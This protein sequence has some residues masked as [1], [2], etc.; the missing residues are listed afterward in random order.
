M[1][2]VLNNKHHLKFIEPH[3][4][5]VIER[6]DDVEPHLTWTLQNVDSLV[7]CTSLLLSHIDELSFHAT[8]DYSHTL[9]MN[10]FNSSCVASLSS[11]SL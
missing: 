10:A 6:F 11:S 7:P 1:L 9:P 8:I 5:E 4:D 3:F 2:E